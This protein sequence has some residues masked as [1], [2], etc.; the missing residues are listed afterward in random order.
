MNRSVFWY[1]TILVTLVVLLSSCKHSNVKPSHS[2]GTHNQLNPMEMYCKRKGSG[3]TCYYINGNK[4]YTRRGQKLVP[5]RVSASRIRDSRRSGFM[6]Q[7]Y[8]YS[9]EVPGLH[10]LK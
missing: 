6:P 2:S 4:V 7:G 1:L 9:L 3:N 5:A 10:E 8:N